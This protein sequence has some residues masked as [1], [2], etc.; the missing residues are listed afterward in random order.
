M[1]MTSLRTLLMIAMLSISLPI[2]VQAADSACDF[3]RYKPLVVDHPRVNA[4]EALKKVQPKYPAIGKSRRAQ[5]KVRVKT[6]V[7][8]K[9]NVVGT[10]ATEGHPLLSASAVSAARQWNFLPN[11]GFA[12]RQRG[13]METFLVFNFVLN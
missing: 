2:C 10:C 9:G 1:M 5:G 13:Y 7:D 12:A 8:R 4:N 6:L 11:F 3:S